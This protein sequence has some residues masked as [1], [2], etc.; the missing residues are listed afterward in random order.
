[1]PREIVERAVSFPRFIDALDRQA[2]AK[3]KK[4]LVN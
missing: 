1:M 2:Q 3:L 4:Y